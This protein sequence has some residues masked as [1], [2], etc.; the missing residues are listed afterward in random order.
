MPEWHAQ[1]QWTL[2]GL[3]DLGQRQSLLCREMCTPMLNALRHAQRLNAKHRLRTGS[4]GGAGGDGG[5]GGAGGAVETPE[6]ELAV[7]APTLD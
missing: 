1:H 7:A 3:W 5:T 4:D 2:M 6:P